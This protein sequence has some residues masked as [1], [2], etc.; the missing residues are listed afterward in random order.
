MPVVPQDYITKAYS[1]LKDNV[2]GF[3]KTPDQFKSLIKSDPT[4]RGK[5]YTAL[6]ENVDGF[7]KTPQTFDSLIV[8]GEKKNSGLSVGANGQ[9]Q[10]SNPTTLPSQPVPDFGMKSFSELAKDQKSA[11]ENTASNNVG[12]FEESVEEKATREKRAADRQAQKERIEKVTPIAID[13]AAKKSLRIKGI[14]PNN[15]AQLNQEKSKLAL[16]IASGDATVGISKDGEAGLYDAPGFLKSFHDHMMTA[17][18]ANKNAREFAKMTVPER[19]EFAKRMNQQTP[20]PYLGEKPTP[21]GSVGALGGDVTPTLGLYGTGALIGAGLESLAPE[22]GG[23]SNL[24]LKPV[25]TFVTNA[26]MGANQKGMQGTLSRFNAIKKLNPDVSDEEAMTRAGKGEDVDRL[27]GIAETALFSKT[28]NELKLG[29]SATGN[30]VKGMAKTAV[31]VGAKT[32]A[33]EGLKDIGHNVEGVTHKS[34]GDIFKDM[35]SAFSENAPMG[36]VLHAF[37]GMVSG[38]VKAPELLK[39]AFKSDIVNKF[40]PD[41]IKAELD[42]NVNSG[43]ITP[44]QADKA[45]SD[46]NQFR[47]VVN[48]VPIGLDDASKASASGLIL[49]RDNI[50]KGAETKDKTAQ[51]LIKQQTESI[52]NQLKEIYRTGKPLEHEI[53]PVTGETFQPQTFDEV[54]K[55]RVEYLADKISKGK[56][57]T[58]PEE[59]QTQQN[60]PQELEKQL[61]RIAKEEKSNNRGKENPNT[62]LTDNVE[63]YLDAK[64]K[65]A[66]KNKIPEIKKEEPVQST[67]AGDNEKPSLEKLL[68]VGDNFS[69][70]NTKDAKV[71]GIKKRGDV[72]FV[73]T[74]KGMLTV[75]LG[76]NSERI[77]LEQNGLSKP[78]TNKEVIPER[79]PEE[80]TKLSREPLPVESIDKKVDIPDFENYNGKEVTTKKVKAFEARDEFRKRLKDIEKIIKCL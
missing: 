40:T 63:K 22:T 75:G 64:S 20:S 71:E 41:Q 49:K 13:N 21:L 57:V 52:D 69:F 19:V 74:D 62:D 68:K 60:F 24:A 25:M 79:T 55:Q 66:E 51:E 15:T 23:L 35:A 6:K 5:V 3:D 48:K 7:D 32:A 8:S 4:Y 65:E 46:L 29:K 17:I 31:D 26:G 72:L 1:A 30:L 53:N 39:S 16:Q 70:G 18:E 9:L 27:A 14:D 77:A 59:L 2:E 80:I 58:D 37:M 38:V 10:S 78:I 33:V 67:V 43:A 44:D 28:G 54:A 73:Y 76:T 50:I 45:V 12:Q 34:V 56:K 42:A 36:A 11:T 61:Q 47:T